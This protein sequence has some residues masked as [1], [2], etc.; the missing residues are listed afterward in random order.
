MFSIGEMSRRSGVKVTTIR[1]YE[2][3]GLL[4]EPDRTAGN[5]RRYDRAA[6]ERLRFIRH[7]RDLGL[8]LN[9]VAELIALHGPAGGNL[10]RAHDIADSQRRWIRARI[11]RL[12]RLAR[13]LDRIAAACDGRHAHEC[14]FLQA[15]GD[16]AACEGPHGAI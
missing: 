5:Q 11:A 1:F 3:K 16:H 2:S 13:E 10:D 9:D 8:P 12:H 7:A 6:L 15:L 4:P 14:N